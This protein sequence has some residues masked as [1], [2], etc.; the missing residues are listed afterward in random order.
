MNFKKLLYVVILSVFFLA[1]CDTKEA[2]VSE[3][4]GPVITCTHT[5]T[6][7]VFDMNDDQIAKFQSTAQTKNVR[8]GVNGDLD[9]YDRVAA[10]TSELDNSINK[11]N[12]L[13]EQFNEKVGPIFGEGIASEVS[14]LEKFK[15]TNYSDNTMD[16]FLDDRDCYDTSDVQVTGLNSDHNYGDYPLD[17]RLVGDRIFV[18]ISSP[19]KSIVSYSFSKKIVQAYFEE[20]F[21]EG[22]PVK[23]DGE[24]IVSYGSTAD[25]TLFTAN[26]LQ[27]LISDGNSVEAVYFSFVTDDYEGRQVLK[28]LIARALSISASEMPNIDFAAV[29]SGY[30]VS[31]QKT[32]ASITVQNDGL[33]IQTGFFGSTTADG[34]GSSSQ[35]NTITTIEEMIKGSIYLIPI[36]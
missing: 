28:P 25:K 30:T 21:R 17:V 19:Y 29:L 9:Y 3:V 34:G 16:Y 27:S 12:T 5:Q 13:V 2:P 32:I 18:S 11:A 8:G 24:N 6:L 15:N 36:K 22:N 4:E 10:D 23:I 7:S 31:G 14:L 35:S 26:T 1:A 20:V 33:N